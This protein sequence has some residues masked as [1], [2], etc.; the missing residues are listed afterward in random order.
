M[1]ILFYMDEFCKKY[2]PSSVT[3]A[4]R[5]YQFISSGFP[6]SSARGAQPDIVRDADVEVI[7]EIVKTFETLLQDELSKLPIFCC[8]DDK[9][10]NLSVDKLLKGGSNGYPQK[11]IAHLTPL[12]LSEIDEAGR[13]L[14]FERSTAAGFHMLRS[15]EIAI[16]QYLLAATGGTLPPLNRQN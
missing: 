5:L 10:G 6:T 1:T 3:Y 15:V 4:T 11:T 14:V 16:R 12:C 9:I 13:C 2:L 7:R 8:D